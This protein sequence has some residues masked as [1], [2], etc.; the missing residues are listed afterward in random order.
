MKKNILLISALCLF[1]FISIEDINAMKRRPASQSDQAPQAQRTKTS[2]DDIVQAAGAA[3][4]SQAPAIAQSQAP[5]AAQSQ[6]PGSFVDWLSK[7]YT[8]ENIIKTIFEQTKNLIVTLVSESDGKIIPIHS[9][10][11]APEPEVIPFL[12]NTHISAE[13]AS[14]DQKITPDYFLTRI[15]KYTQNITFLHFLIAYI[16]IKRLI[17]QRSPLI[18][19]NIT[20]YRIYLAAFVEASKWAFDQYFS[21][22][23]YAKLGG[24]PARELYTI[25]YQFLKITN[26]NLFV[27][28]EE[29]DA[30]LK[31]MFS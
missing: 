10:D 3:A 1:A 17:V 23:H 7:N 24:I 6:T 22:Q 28:A 19:N 31:E 14:P 25:E 18:F 12:G 20:F 2:Q 16:Y 21:T 9:L 5:D 30:T 27:S 8:E 11:I 4:Q 26:F 13:Y 29:I 15:K